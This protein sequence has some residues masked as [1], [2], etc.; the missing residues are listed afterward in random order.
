MDVYIPQSLELKSRRRRMFSS[1]PSFL[2]GSDQ[3]STS[4][5]NS[6]LTHT[7]LPQNVLRTTGFMDM[8]VD[9]RLP[10]HGYVFLPFRTAVRTREADAACL[11]VRKPVIY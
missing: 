10:N 3:P 7:R 5:W 9:D 8:S 6:S 1:V 4:S 2:A 11:A